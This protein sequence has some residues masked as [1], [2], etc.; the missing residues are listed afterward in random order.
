MQPMHLHGYHT[1]VWFFFFV[2]ILVWFFF[3][4][5]ILVCGY[6]L[7]TFFFGRK[8]GN[9]LLWDFILQ[10][11]L[12]KLHLQIGTLGFGIISCSWASKMQWYFWRVG[13]CWFG[14]TLEGVKKKCSDLQ[15]EKENLSIFF[16]P[17]MSWRLRP[18]KKKVMKIDANHVLAG[19]AD[20]VS[21]KNWELTK[22]DS[23]LYIKNCSY[24]SN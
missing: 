14:L 8:I 19:K 20:Y 12:A 11:F 4:V 10:F 18:K 23:K 7:E 6:K 3:V 16:F 15:N 5:K 9:F 2:N 21:M 17:E 22:I 24:I 1:S 13:L